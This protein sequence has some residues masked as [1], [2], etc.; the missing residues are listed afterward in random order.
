VQ[1]QAAQVRQRARAGTLNAALP[2]RDL[3]A[4]VDAT[5]DARALLGRAVD[6]LMLSARAARR[7]LKVARTVADLEEEPRVLPRMVA[8][9]LGYRDTREPR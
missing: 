3:D 2:D 9:A 6:T 5:P 1:V 4:L 7:V 8:E